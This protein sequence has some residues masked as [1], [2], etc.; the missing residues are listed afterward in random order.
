[1]A[2]FARPNLDNTQFKQLKGGEPLT[3][4]GQTQI[5]TTSGLTLIGDAG[6]G[7]AAYGGMYIPIIATGASNNFVLTYDSSQKAIVLKQSTSSGGT[8]VYPYSAATTCTVGGLDAGSD[9][10]N[11]EVVD[12]IQCMVSPTLFPTLSNPSVSSFTISPTTTLYEIGACPSICGTVCF[13][14][15][16]INPVYPPTLGSGCNSCGTIC[17]VYNAFG[18]PLTCV[19]NAPSVPNF[20]FG[21]LCVNNASNTISTNICHCAGYQPYDSSG[22]PFGSPL[23]ISATTT[24]SKTITGVYPYYWGTLTCAAAAGVGRP[25]A[26]CIKDG[27]TGGTLTNGTCNKVVAPSTGTL[28]VTFGSTSSEYLWFATPAASTT[29]T[30]WF[31]TSLNNG[32]IGGGVGTGSACNLFPDQDTVTDVTTVCWSGQSYKIYIS[33]YQSASATNMELR[34]S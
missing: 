19:I 24:V 31:E 5:A 2:F 8:T 18:A 27:I 30:C 34:N 7:P 22:A 14:P 29:K 26:C 12:I 17:Y 3:L 20:P 13:N 1:M 9:I 16:S 4:S 23:A 28:N 33:N 10:F 25:T 32:L 11:D 15:G 6:T 21:N